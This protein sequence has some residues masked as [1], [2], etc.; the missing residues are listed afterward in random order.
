MA[1]PSRFDS[2]TG[3][4]SGAPQQV[5]E[6]RQIRTTAKATLSHYRPALW[7]ADHEWK[8]GVQFE[9][10]EHRALQV[11]PTGVRFTDN[12]GQPSQSTHA[13]PST[14]AVSSSRLA[15]SRATP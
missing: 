6:G 5:G 1:T 9:R 14:P 7:R 2:V 8:T 4:T 13:I 15:R 3:V 10:G 12:N 11:I